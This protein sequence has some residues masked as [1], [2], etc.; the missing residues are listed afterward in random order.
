MDASVLLW[1]VAVVLVVVGL[2]GLV[3]PA[4][5]G[6]PVLLAGLVMAAWAEDFA[7]VGAWT[8]AF[9][10]L[11]ALLAYALDFAATAFGARRFGASPRAAG[12]AALGAL[13]GIFFG[14]PG[15]LLG[16][17]L[18]AVAGELSVRRRLAE[19]GR[20]G[21]GA[22]VGLVIGGAAKL[23]LGFSMVGL[24]LLARLWGTDA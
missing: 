10:A 22:T 18:G 16:P 4:I 13:V 19:A 2:A 12:G 8:L 1:I 14:L 6:P 24:F 5:P 3:L 9:L 15:I 17:F 23:A 21:L 7:H 20:A 11:M